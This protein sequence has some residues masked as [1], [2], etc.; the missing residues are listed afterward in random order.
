[1][2]RSPTPLTRFI[3]I[4]GGIT[5]LLCRCGTNDRQNSHTESQRDR[6]VQLPGG[7]N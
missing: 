6:F 4:G 5:L 2:E 3:D 7:E 1:M